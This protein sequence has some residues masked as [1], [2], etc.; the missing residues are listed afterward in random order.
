MFE[1]KFSNISLVLYRF[2]DVRLGFF[3]FSW[4]LHQENVEA[5]STVVLNAPGPPRGVVLPGVHLVHGDP[6]SF[7]LFD[8][9]LK[10]CTRADQGGPGGP[11]GP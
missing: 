5:W 2:S 6:L 7:T 11:G 10:M 8:L 9:L 3:R 4:V 1:K